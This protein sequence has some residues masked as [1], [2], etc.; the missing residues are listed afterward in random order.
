MANKVLFGLQNVYYAVVTTAVADGATTVT[1][2]TPKR[3][4][5]AV[6]LSVEPKGDRSDFYADNGDY[7]SDAPNQGYTG[8]LEVA[9]AT[10]DLLKDVFGWT[11]DT[12]GVLFEDATAKTKAI[13]L[14]F[15]FDGDVNATRH[16][17]YN[18][19]LS[20]PKF[21]SK[22]AEAT[23]EP[24]TCTMDYTA[25]RPADGSAYPHGKVENETATA[26]Q[27]NAFF[28]AVYTRVS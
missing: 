2:G 1:Y 4:P 18:V 7:Y 6:A 12:N 28:T 27:Y 25:S 14:L 21:S 11:A 8:T 16:V 5:G 23:R 13:A 3:L 26:T 20:R 22:T 9:K 15:E 24:Q 10:D 17:L 19:A